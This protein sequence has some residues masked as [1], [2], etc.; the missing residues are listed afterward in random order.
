MRGD[1]LGYGRIISHTVGNAKAMSPCR[2][3]EVLAIYAAR[4][5]SFELELLTDT[6][7]LPR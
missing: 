7:P 6:S 2:F 3:F 1:D 5:A 4:R